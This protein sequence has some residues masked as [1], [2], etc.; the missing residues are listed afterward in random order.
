[1][2]TA[3]YNSQWAAQNRRGSTHAFVST[4]LLMVARISWCP[5][6]SSRVSGLYFSTLGLASVKP[7]ALL[8]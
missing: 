6:T 3:G 4:N 2:V 5:E 8:E 1:M 7:L